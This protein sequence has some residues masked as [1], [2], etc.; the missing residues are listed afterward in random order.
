MQK[1]KIAAKAIIISRV[2]TKRQQQSGYSLT[3]QTSD[4]K[5]YCADNNL[6]ILKIYE[7]AESATTGKRKIFM[8]AINFAASQKEI[9]AVVE[10]EVNILQSSNFKELEM[11]KKLIDDEKIELHFCRQNLVIH[12]Y[13]TSQEKMQWDLGIKL[14]QY[15]SDDARNN[16]NNITEYKLHHG[17]WISLPSPIGYLHSRDRAKRGRD[18]IF[19]DPNRAP[20]IKRIFE[21]YAKGIYTLPEIIRKNKGM[22]LNQFKR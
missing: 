19:I 8:E 7:L 4:S 10:C 20:L 21:L 15:R 14:V 1:R 3:G 13:S 11:L 5:E 17:E 2:S 12:K 6:E 9:V 16:V 22:G 18:R